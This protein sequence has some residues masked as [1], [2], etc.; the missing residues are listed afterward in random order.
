MPAIVSCFHNFFFLTLFS[1]PIPTNQGMLAIG[2]FAVAQMRP[3]WCP[4]EI[5]I[6]NAD[7]ER[8]VD[9]EIFRKKNRLDLLIGWMCKIQP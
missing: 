5:I 9:S 6:S 7:G 3:A 1:G 8:C 2:G 4:N